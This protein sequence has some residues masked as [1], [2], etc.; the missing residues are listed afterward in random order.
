MDTYLPSVG[1]QGH[2]DRDRDHL[3]PMGL[4]Q[5]PNYPWAMVEQ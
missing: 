4:N 1:R 5:D 3:D 2:Q